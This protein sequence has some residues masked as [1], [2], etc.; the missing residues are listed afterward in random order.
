M[1]F[2]LSAPGA[3]FPPYDF[4]EHS[5]LQKKMSTADLPDESIISYENN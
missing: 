1:L 4:M 3:A 2:G 5:K